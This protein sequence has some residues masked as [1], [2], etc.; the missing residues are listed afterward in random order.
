MYLNMSSLDTGLL[1]GALMSTRPQCLDQKHQR[2][3]KDK[4]N[5]LQLASFFD[6]LYVDFYVPT[7]QEYPFVPGPVQR[8]RRWYIDEGFVTQPIAYTSRDTHKRSQS[9]LI[10]L[11]DIALI[12]SIVQR[13]VYVSK[14]TRLLHLERHGSACGG[15]IS[16]ADSSCS[17]KSTR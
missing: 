7:S 16:N 3:G 4:N 14:H 13:P 10:H 15:L 5:C 2:H 17:R 1:I 11:P 8:M 12:A 9:C 6:A